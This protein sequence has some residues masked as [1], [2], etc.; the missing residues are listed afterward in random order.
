M[1]RGQRLRLALP[2]SQELGAIREHLLAC[3]FD[4]PDL[5]MPGLHR[6]GDP[7]D[8]G[9]E[10]EIFR[11]APADVG[12]YVEH[13]ISH[14]GV[15]STEL[16]GETE[17]QVWRPYTF[18]FGQ[19]PIAFAAPRGESFASLSTRPQVRIATPFPVLA[20]EVFALRGMPVE[21][22]NVSDSYTACLLGLADAF[23]DRI[24]DP[25]PMKE[26]DF[27]VLE[28]LGYARL[29]LVVNRA[30]GSR[31]RIA[32]QRLVQALQENAPQ[33]LPPL[34][35]PYELMEDEFLPGPYLEWDEE[36]SEVSG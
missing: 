10:F 22:V 12:I 16:L 34:E 7:L 1:A 28:V 19:Y 18:P 4:V 6:V 23:L 21:V 33:S 35:I 32:I 9:Y 36:N 25:T 29:K 15:M 5:S 2:H 30:L 31:R 26:N 14:L 24:V 3:G 17:S 13:A 27:R 11:L 8:C 20:K